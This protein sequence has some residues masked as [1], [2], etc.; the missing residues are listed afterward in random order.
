MRTRIHLE[1]SAEPSLT[2]RLRGVVKALLVGLMVVNA[3]L[4][5]FGAVQHAGF[6]IGPF[7]EP[8]I[9]PATLVESLCGFSL[10]WGAA[11]ISN[12]Q[13][14]DSR[15]ALTSN[16]IA[17]SGVLLGIAALAVGAGPR[18]TSN[19]LYHRIMLLLIGASLLA[20]VCGRSLA[21]K[22]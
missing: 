15:I 17:L 12:K 14:I 18:T 19:D 20:V 6:T 16:C 4:F 5:F 1:D 7:H 9:L 10:L 21:N 13:A 8:R 11:R 2:P 22:R 3:G